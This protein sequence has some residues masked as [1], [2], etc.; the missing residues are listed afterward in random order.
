MR[1]K[2]LYTFQKSYTGISETDTAKIAWLLALKT[3]RFDLGLCYSASFANLTA[4]P[5]VAPS[6]RIGWRVGP[7]GWLLSPRRLAIKL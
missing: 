2:P 6:S 7:K 3:D 1:P 4:E 5:L